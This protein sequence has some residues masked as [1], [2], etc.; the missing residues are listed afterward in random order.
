MCVF[1][2]YKNCASACMCSPSPVCAYLLICVRLTICVWVC[3]CHSLSH[4]LAPSSA[5]IHSF[6]S[7]SALLWCPGT[8]SPFV[9]HHGGGGRKG[10]VWGWF[11]VPEL[12]RWQGPSLLSVH[13][14]GETLWLGLNSG[15]TSLS[16]AEV[17]RQ[18]CRDSDWHELT[19]HIKDPIH[20]C[21]VEYS[22]L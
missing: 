9:V 8:I 17:P 18:T 5:N 2:K 14:R 3:V 6:Q 11:L 21:G 13:P 7:P 15:L 16:A 1:L 20:N 12:W 10:G 22:F 19:Q 4:L